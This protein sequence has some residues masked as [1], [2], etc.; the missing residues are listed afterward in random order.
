MAVG[1][2]SGVAETL[3]EAA[4]VV[5]AAGSGAS[6]APLTVMVPGSR[7]LPERDPGSNRRV[8]LEREN[9]NVSLF[10]GQVAVLERIFQVSTSTFKMFPDSHHLSPWP[11]PAVSPL[12]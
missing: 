8:G 10:S 6:A 2:P 4:A 5:G 11:S 3:G 12:N 1:L 9:R 7:G